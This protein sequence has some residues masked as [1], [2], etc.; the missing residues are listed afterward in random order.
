MSRRLNVYLHAV[1][2]GILEQ[3]DSGELSFQYDTDYL[4]SEAFAV[5][6]SLPLRAEKY[7]G[8]IVRAFFSGL[9]PDELVRQRLARYL[10]VSHKNAFSLLEAIGG[11][12]AGALALFPEGSGSEQ[13]TG[14]GVE[15]LTQSQLVEVLGLLRQRPLL[16]GDDG[17]RLSLAGA[18][19]KLAVGVVDGKIALV[20]GNAPTTH[21]L[22]P[23]IEGITD[24]VTNEW[25][26]MQLSANIGIE[27]PRVQMCRVKNIPYF[28]V[29][30]YDRKNGVRVHQEDFCQALG[31]LPEM[32][33]EREGGPSVLQCQS[34]LRQYSK[35]P[36]VDQIDLLNRVIFNY[37]IGNADAHGKNFSLLYTD[38]K[39]ELAPAYDLL[40]TA[41]YPELS[42]KMAM[43]IGGKYK[44]DELFRRHW[45]QLV[46]ETVV[47]QKNLVKQIEKLCEKSVVECRALKAQLDTPSVIVGKVCDLIEKRAERLQGDSHD[48]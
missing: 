41:V 6:L 7:S 42:A 1:R 46:P 24:S 20:K 34:V 2:V 9:L 37:L 30:R 3:E 44:P 16:A 38:R 19:D 10:G 5:S 29:E 23:Q 32:K 39:P 22:K 33:Y 14:S 47:A 36:A 12:C 35:R 13:D 17:L 31:V 26:C 21:I 43:K 48:R 8:K 45:L 27:T 28:L 40:S 18:Q 15:V 11:E 25:F 4:T